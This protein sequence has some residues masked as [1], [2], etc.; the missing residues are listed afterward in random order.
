MESDSAE[1]RSA[2]VS[3]EQAEPATE[4]LP[5]TPHEQSAVPAGRLPDGR[6]VGPV[7]A[8]HPSHAYQP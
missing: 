6:S 8:V 1:I 4:Q 2:G 3:H 7:I 5:L